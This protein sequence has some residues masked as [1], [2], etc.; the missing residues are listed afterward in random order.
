MDNNLDKLSG[1]K[2]TQS[3][4]PQSTP[5]SAEEKLRKSMRG[6]SHMGGVGSG[7]LDVNRTTSLNNTSTKTSRKKV[8]G[9]VLD[10]GAIEETNSQSIETKGKRNNVIIFILS[11][12]L[13]VSVVYLIIAILNYNQSKKDPNC[14]YFIESDVG[15]QWLIEGKSKTEF[16]LRQ[17]LAPDMRY[18]VDS[19]IKINTTET[20]VVEISI[21]VK[22]KGEHILI[23]GLD[24]PNKNLIP[25]ENSNTYRGEI[26][27][28]GIVHM[29]DGLDFTLAPSH[30][31]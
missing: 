26:S 27:G 4:R 15:A 25:V 3:S 16:L 11:L 30:R 8:G 19:K 1:Q 23:A 28:G 24:N 18:M 20:V 9:V 5:M 17:G 12:L 29:F 21:V 6:L 7:G 31:M 22:L 2:R 13:V 10:I 14:K